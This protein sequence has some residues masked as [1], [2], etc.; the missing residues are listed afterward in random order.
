MQ[1]L[2]LSLLAAAVALSVGSASFAQGTP[3]T[4]DVLKVDVVKVATGF[5]ATR[6]I[7]ET[8]VNDANETV[9]KVDDLIIVP[10][11][12]VPVLVLS[13]GGFLGVGTRLVAVPYESL[14]MQ[15]KKLLL[16]G[17][18]RDTLKTLPE[19]KYAKD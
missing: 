1:R 2:A 3:Q 4:L 18:T 5:R 15:D 12:K 8:V 10:D 16:T 7:G 17:A 9:G 13:V 11:G 19:F 14:E 6:I